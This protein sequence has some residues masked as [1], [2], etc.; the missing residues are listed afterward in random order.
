MFL[1]LTRLLGM[2]AYRNAVK[3]LSRPKQ[4]NAVRAQIE[5]LLEESLADEI[6][7]TYQDE[8]A[9]LKQFGAEAS[10]VYYSMS[11][12]DIYK[13]L[14]FGED[15]ILGLAAVRDQYRAYGRW[16]QTAEAQEFWANPPPGRLEAINLT[17]HQA[18]GVHFASSSMVR[19]EPFFLFDA[20]G[21]GKTAQSAGVILMRPWL[22]EWCSKHTQLP[23]AF[24]EFSIHSLHSRIRGIRHFQTAL[25]QLPGLCFAGLM[26]SNARRTATHRC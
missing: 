6:P 10:S 17:W 22:R 21:V 14:G 26:T 2:K 13:T 5:R 15:G 3:L 20:V 4:M 16:E 25:T 24:G 8:F 9:N 12:P 11:R 7:S 1:E 23:P 18:V 19:R